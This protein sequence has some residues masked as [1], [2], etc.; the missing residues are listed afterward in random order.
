MY[1]ILM[2]CHGGSR[3]LLQASPRGGTDAANRGPA[4]ISATK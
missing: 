1:K 4:A 3:R 2:V